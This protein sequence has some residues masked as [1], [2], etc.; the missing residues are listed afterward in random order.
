MPEWSFQDRTEPATPKRRR[1]ARE[2]GNVPRSVEVNSALIL[3]VGV[4]AL[5]A[6]GGLFLGQLSKITKAVLGGMAD[7][8]LT[9]ESL[10][11]LALAGAEAAF[12][13]MA[14]IVLVL[15]AVGLL[16]NA[17]QG[18]LVLSTEP[19]TPRLTKISPVRGLQ[20]LFSARS[21]V[22]LAKGVFKLVVVAVI[23]FATMYAHFRE[24]FPLVEQGAGQILGFA[25]RVAFDVVFRAAL[26]LLVM[27][28]FDFAY[29][30][31]E[32][33]KNLRMTKEEVKEEYRQTE[34]DPLVRARIRSL[35]RE[36]SRKR[37]IASVPKAD[38][39]ITNPVHVAVALMYR[40]HE[41]A[42]PKVVA[43]GA[44]R[45]AEKIKEVARQH[46][47]PIVENPWLAQM[48]FKKT[49]V[50]QEI[51]LELYQAVAEILAYVYRLKS[52]LYSRAYARPT[53]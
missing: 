13:M 50:G 28:V 20:R 51:P 37:M 19:L 12:A 5:W 18:G 30:R 33:E 10:P 46:D 40:V 1:E 35:M 21:A 47:I 25:A 31:Y 2:K 34:G 23:G 32:W 14:P 36:R 15:I 4:G 3:L 27:A 41:M 17:A 26:A 7:I 44:R 24:L 45:V 43:K 49:Q 42:A 29:Q 53:R 11:T 16:A 8:E 6:T 22:E 38:V 48:L 39:V 52:G 9:P